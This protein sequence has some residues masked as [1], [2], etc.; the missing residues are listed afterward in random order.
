VSGPDSSSTTAAGSKNEEALT[1]AEAL[2]IEGNAL[3]GKGDFADA[4]KRYQDGLLALVTVGGADTKRAS[5]TRLLLHLNAALAEL[6]RGNLGSAVEHATGA[7]ACDPKSAKALYRRGLARVRLSEHVGHESEASLA[8]I[9]FER[10]LELEPGDNEVRNQVKSLRSSLR[11]EKKDLEKSQKQQFKG[12]FDSGKA[13]YEEPQP[14]SETQPVLRDDGG[15]GHKILLAADQLSFHYERSA[16]VLTEVSLELR[17]GWCVGLVGNNA[18]GKTTLAR[19]LTGRLKPC[20]GRLQQH[21]YREEETSDS[22]IVAPRDGSWTISAAAALGAAIA[23]SAVLTASGKDVRAL[24]AQLLWWHWVLLTGCVGVVIFTIKALLNWR[25]ARNA[26]A[27]VGRPAK[28]TVLHVSSEASDKE[29]ISGRK[30]IEAVIGEKLPRQMLKEAKREQVVSMLKAGGFQM[31]N[32][33]TGQP[34]GSA[35]DYVKDGLMFGQL[36]GGQKHLIYVLRCFAS[37]PDVMLCDELLGGLDAFRQPRVLHMLRRLKNE[38]NMAVL[39]I[40]CELNQLRLVADSFAFLESGRIVEH[41]ALMD[42]LDD[43]RH[44]ATKEYVGQYRSMPGCSKIGGKLAEAYMGLE[45]DAALAADWL[46][47]KA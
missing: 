12:I 29:E 46:P 33:E 35:E 31:Y 4:S 16:P 22:A 15:Q 43:P 40:S 34:V 23:V 42:V 1:R 45:A 5:D 36:S 21:R 6:R 17:A 24:S 19:L 27:G 41:G 8:L 3:F 28:R 30:T 32:Q 20:K 39:Y 38:A 11:V 44:P 47:P 14:P 10:A 25:S 26:S 2:R 37:R 7:L 18:S 9:D 13:L